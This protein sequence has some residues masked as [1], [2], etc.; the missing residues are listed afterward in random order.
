MSRSQHLTALSKIVLPNGHVT[1]KLDFLGTV[2]IYNKH[3]FNVWRRYNNVY[4]IVI[5][6]FS[7]D[8]YYHKDYTIRQSVQKILCLSDDQMNEI[9]TIEAVSYKHRADVS[10]DVTSLRWTEIEHRWYAMDMNLGGILQD[11]HSIPPFSDD[12]VV[13]PPLDDS[14]TSDDGLFT[15]GQS[16]QIK[17]EK[18]EPQL[19]Q[20]VQNRDRPLAARNLSD[21]FAEVDQTWML[22]SPQENFMVLR[23]GTRIEKPRH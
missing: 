13:M 5:E 12:D 7:G 21:R 16:E 4:E 10:E 1:H 23:N 19:E 15:Q 3:Y 2:S 9:Y 20:L 8:F 22:L 17:Q 11:F 6:D 14:S 18:K